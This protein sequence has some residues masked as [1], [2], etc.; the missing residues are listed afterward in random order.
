M[1]LRDVWVCGRLARVKSA[2][3]L[4]DSL[5][6]LTAAEGWSSGRGSVVIAAGVSMN[7]PT[8]WDPT[9]DLPNDSNANTPFKLKQ[10]AAS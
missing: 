10:E 8:S 6:W 1:E 7:Y 3:P 9:A 4:N 2:C 5:L